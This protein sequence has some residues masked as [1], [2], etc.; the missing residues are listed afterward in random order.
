MHALLGIKFVNLNLK[1]DWFKKIIRYI[2][3][4]CN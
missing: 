2:L 1:G 4:F 3:R